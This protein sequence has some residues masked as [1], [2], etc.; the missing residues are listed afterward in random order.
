[1]IAVRFRMGV[2]WIY[3]MASQAGAVTLRTFLH[4]HGRKGEGNQGEEVCKHR[5]GYHEGGGN[6]DAERSRGCLRGDR[7]RPQLTCHSTH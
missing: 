6:S 5:G 4:Q 1:M 7:G 3:G 2:R